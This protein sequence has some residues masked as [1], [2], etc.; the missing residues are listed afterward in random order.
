MSAYT[1]TYT[2]THI[3]G[4]ERER[5]RE[6]ETEIGRQR[7]IKGNKEKHYNTHNWKQKIQ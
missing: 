1:H 5:Q 6:K 2:H 7:E 4:Y 3:H